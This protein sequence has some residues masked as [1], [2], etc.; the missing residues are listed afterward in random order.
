MFKL[1]NTISNDS[2]L[3]AS[4]LFDRSS[5]YPALL[6]NLKSARNQVIIEGT[7]INLQP[8]DYNSNHAVLLGDNKQLRN[9]HLD[10]AAAI[11]TPKIS[12]ADLRICNN[13][14]FCKS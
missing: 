8:T 6:R 14:T 3:L 4:N 11:R 12:S 9:A 7:V 1:R 2:A 10:N 5:F 13:N